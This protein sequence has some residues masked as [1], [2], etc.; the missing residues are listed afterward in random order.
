[1]RRRGDS[2]APEKYPP[3]RAGKGLHASVLIVIMAGIL[4]Q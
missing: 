4:A 3:F 2:Q 1:M